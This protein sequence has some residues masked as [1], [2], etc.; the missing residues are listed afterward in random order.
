M[1]AQAS[2]GVDALLRPDSA[3]RLI[4]VN[5]D[6]GDDDL[7]NRRLE[8]TLGFGLSTIGGRYVTTPA[9]GFGLT[10]VEREVSH[11]WRLAEARGEGLVF[12]LDIE[13]L[14]REPV[15]GDAGPE[16]RVVFGLGWQLEGTRREGAA[17]EIR[18]EGAHSD[19]ANDNDAP[20]TLVGVSMTTRW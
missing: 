18:L 14:R 3:E 2:G 6:E 19:A 8:A 10:E 20:E 15:T 16:H 12:G 1:G 5:D 13:A 4:A 17:L 11:S 9:L 7:R